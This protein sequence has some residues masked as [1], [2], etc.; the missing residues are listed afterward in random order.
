[1]ISYP[2]NMAPGKDNLT[3]S[4]FIYPIPLKSVPEMLKGV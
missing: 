2:Y 3:K 4:K 1:M